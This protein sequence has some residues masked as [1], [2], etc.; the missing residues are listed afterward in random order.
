MSSEDIE[1]EPIEPRMLTSRERFIQG[2]SAFVTKVKRDNKCDL[3]T[4]VKSEQVFEFPV[5]GE[6]ATGYMRAQ[7]ILLISCAH[8]GNLITVK[9][10][11]DKAVSGELAYSDLIWLLP[12]TF[13]FAN[14]DTL[15]VEETAKVTAP[16]HNSLTEAV[17]EKEE[18]KIALFL[19]A[20]ANAGQIISLKQV[21]LLCETAKY[22]EYIQVIAI[23]TLAQI[24]KQ[25]PTKVQGFFLQIF[26]DVSRCE[27]VRIMACIV[28]LDSAPPQ[29]VVI[30]MANAMLY[31]DNL[32]I[33]SF[34]Y[35]HMKAITK[36][37]DLAYYNLTTHIN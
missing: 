7:K 31:E 5:G 2:T 28:L 10:I 4:Q 6:D 18:N 1:L 34:V 37:R 35:S 14:P 22:P 9:F 36:I 23:Q 3:I 20:I 17:R 16:L 21:K 8:A 12:T 33:A 19:K 26:M 13:H 30:A 32:H 27:A 15:K 24:S 29:P 11:K 25:D